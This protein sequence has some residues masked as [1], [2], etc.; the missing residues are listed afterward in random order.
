V[1]GGCARDVGGRES[2][3]AVFQTDGGAQAREGKRLILR[4]RDARWGHGALGRNSGARGCL[5]IKTW[6]PV[7]RMCDLVI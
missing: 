1:G 2:A 3:R 4:A 7:G 6:Q 5:V